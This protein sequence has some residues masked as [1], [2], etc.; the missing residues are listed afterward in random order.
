MLIVSAGSSNGSI[1]RDKDG[2]FLSINGSNNG[3]KRTIVDIIPTLR[4]FYAKNRHLPNV[5]ELVEAKFKKMY[6]QAIIVSETYNDIYKKLNPELY[7]KIMDIKTE[8]LRS[9]LLSEE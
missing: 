5:D 8:D 7:N 3:E 6:E 1:C 9:L 4:S 2:N